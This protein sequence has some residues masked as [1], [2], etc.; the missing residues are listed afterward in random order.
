MYMDND[1]KDKTLFIL[2][3][4]GLIYREYFAFAKRPLTNKNGENISAVHGFFNNLAS[5]LKNFKPD[6]MVVALDSKTP[7]FRHEKYADYKANRAA[8]PDDLKSQFPWIEEILSSL[9]MKA[10]RADGFE[11]DDVIATLAK[12]ASADGM[13]V[14]VLSGDKDLLQL[15]DD[16]VKIL[17]PGKKDKTK[18]WEEVDSAGVLE[19]WGVPPEKICDVLSLTGDTADNVPGVRGVGDK[20][21]VKFISQYGS[22]EGLYEHADEIKGAI[23]EKVR[24]D[25]D[26]AFFS[27]ELISL[28]YDAPLCDSEKS[29]KIDYGEFLVSSLDFKAASDSLKAFSLPKAASAFASLADGVLA[30]EEVESVQK[31]AGEYKA[32]TNLSELAAF[33]DSAIK[34][35]KVAFDTETD[36]LNT[37]NAVILGFSLCTEKGKGIY[38][39]LVPC[40]GVENPVSKKDAFDLLRKL[41]ASGMTIAMHNA[42]FDLE[43]LYSNCFCSDVNAEIEKSVQKKKAEA[44]SKKKN[45]D[46]FDLFAEFEEEESD[47]ENDSE[48]EKNSSCENPAKINYG[49]FD[50]FFSSGA[51]IFDTMIA[52]WVLEPDKSEKNAFSLEFLSEKILKLRGVEFDEIVE[53]GKTFADVPIDVASSYSSE[54]ADFTL[55]LFEKLSA[56]LEKEK[57][58]GVFD[59]EMKVLPVLAKMEIEGIH[60]SSDVLKNYGVELSRSIEDLQEEIYAAAGHPFNISSTRQLGAVLFEEMNLKGSKKTK[61]GS[62][63]TDEESLKSLSDNAFV[64]KILDYRGKTKLLSTYVDAL[65]LLA[66]ENGRVHTSFVQTGTATGRLSSREPNLQNIPVREESGRRI[67]SAFT[68][69]PGKVL[70][71]ADYAQIELVVLAHLSGDEN[72]CKAFNDGVD[73]HKSTA[74]LI[75]GVPMEEVTAEERRSAKTFNFGIIYGMSAFRLANDLKIGFREANDFIDSY[76]QIYSGVKEFFEKTVKDAENTGFTTTISGR[77]REIKNISASNA[78]IREAAVRMAKNS[79]IQGSAADIVKKAMLDVDSALREN[80]TGAKLLLQVHDELIFECDDD[81]KA[82]SDTIALVTDKMEHAFS[83]RVPLRVSVECGKNWG[84]FH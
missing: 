14:F 4:Y 73:V 47:S 76:F 71:S 61:S 2:D 39:P 80:P 26:N 46:E 59:T 27:K 79:P 81:E 66:D 78:K 12:K 31:N 22:V 15:V 30:L 63:S 24:A 44:K 29:D 65:P 69:M 53:K 23:G 1:L 3:S 52:S 77:R 16:N 6:M 84:E 75:Y 45:D 42:K 60:I 41:F 67:R 49:N 13:K 11:A 18:M 50:S 19:E 55:Q 51:K 54:D 72:L 25:K 56:M 10:I 57:L 40:E 20:T 64:G 28:R 48:N 37:R 82:I 70:I 17:R 36:S 58:T 35:G 7:T 8:T 5:T 43:V 68:A 83:L 33:I 9:K 74:S 21:A 32:V 38:V 34:N 62:Y